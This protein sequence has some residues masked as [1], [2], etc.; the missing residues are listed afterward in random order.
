M[1]LQFRHIFEDDLLLNKVTVRLSNTASTQGRVILLE[2]SS[3]F[4]VTKG[5]TT[6]WVSTNVSKP[7]PIYML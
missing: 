7:L 4:L 2:T 5:S 6:L 3:P 1:K